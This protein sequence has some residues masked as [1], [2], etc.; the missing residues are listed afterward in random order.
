MTTIRTVAAHEVV[1]A[2]FPRQVTER[3]QIGM[4]AGKAIDS[5]LAQ[6][7]HMFREGR[8]PTLSSV[9]RIATETLDDEL[10]ASMLRLEPAVRDRQVREITAVLRAF[11]G[12]E[13]MGLPRPRSR[14][15]LIDGEVGIYAQPDYWNGRDRFYEMK[16]YHAD[17]IPPDVMLQIRLFQLAFPGFRAALAEFDRHA[18]VVRPQIREIG[19]VGPEETDR[20]L[21]IARDV[22]RSSGQE[23]VLE[24]VDNPVVRYGIES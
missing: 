9:D 3:D 22:A 24:Y 19:A 7:S 6:F 15:I 17:P 1:R 2:T 12:S 21:R 23:K 5:A 11:R 4:A 8:R 18:P 13:V 10:E 16:S 14:L 20:V